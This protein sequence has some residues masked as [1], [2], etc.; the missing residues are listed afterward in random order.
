MTS[1]ELRPTI[2]TADAASRHPQPLSILGVTNVILRNRRLVAAAIV[3]VAVIAIP[4]AVLAPRVYA[5]SASFIPAGRKAPSPVSGIAAQFGISVA[6][7]DAQQSPDFYV[8]LLHSR[9]VQNHVLDTTYSFISPKGPYKGTLLDY[10]GGPAT[11]L[12]RRRVA[13]LRALDGQIIA[14]TSLKTG[15]VLL[16]VRGQS[17]TLVADIARNLLAGVDRFNRAR[18]QSQSASERQFAEEQVANAASDLR[19][20]EDRLQTF[21][22][23]N[24]AYDRAPRLALDHERLVR[25]VTMRQQLYTS[26]A[27]AYAQARIDAVRD[28]PSVVVLESP[29]VPPDPEGRGLI[30]SGVLALMAGLLLGVLLAFV[31]EHIVRTRELH[32]EEEAEYATLRAAAVRDLR[33]PFRLFGVKR[34]R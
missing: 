33:N 23:E 22:D 15:A 9:T 32:P 24:R 27:Q 7:T 6:N 28:N 3:V 25:E 19:A 2:R 29:E 34:R 21:Q 14:T 18:V 30:K 11:P 16:T 17:P 1:R 10:Y 20:A 13:A 12:A 5:S 31:R 4:R 8:S 26:L